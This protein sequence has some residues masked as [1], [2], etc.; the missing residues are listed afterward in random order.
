MKTLPVKTS[1]YLI[2]L[3]L[4]LVLSACGGDND[5]DVRDL[6]KNLNEAQDEITDLEKR[7]N[8]LQNPGAGVRAPLKMTILHMNDHHSHIAPETFSY[9]VAGL[10]LAARTGTNAELSSVSVTYGGFPM[11]VSLFDR[12]A[13]QSVN[14]VKIHA[15]DAVTGTLYY[16]LFNGA[17]DAAMMNQVCFDAFALGNHEFD[18]GD[19]GLANFLDDLKSG[20]CNTAVLAANVKPGANSAI[21]DGYIQP[22]MIRDVQGQKVGF[23]GI[24]IADK[25]KNSSKPDTDTQFLDEATTAQH[26][27]DELRGQGVNKIVLVTHY[28]YE[29]DKLLASQL[30]GVDVIVGGDSHTLLGGESFKTLGFNPA[31]EYPTITKNRDGDTVCIVQAWEYGHLLGKLEVS[32]DADG[33]VAAC[34]G[35]PYMPVADNFTYTHGAGDI[36]TLSASDAFKVRQQITKLP[37]V[38]AVVPDATTENLL[39][40]YNEEVSVLEQQVIGTTADNLCL[41]RFPG[42]SRS[43]ICNASETSEYG[44]DI[45]NIIA[46]AFMT[47]TPTADIAIQNGGG[48]RVDVAAGDIT[49][50]EAVN[51]L[52]FTNTL[53]TLELT[54]AQIKAV[55]EDAMSSALRVGGSSG[56]YPYAS[57]L[58]YHVNAS[59]ADGSRISN[60]EVNPRVN[61]D[62]AAINTT[63]TYTVVTNDFIAAGQDGYATFG[64]LY[65]AGL[66]VNT[67]TLYTQAFISYITRLTANGDVLTKLPAS[68]YSTQQY[69]GRDG[70]NHSLENCSGY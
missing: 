38:V 39:S 12:L 54:G 21:S 64:G 44:S 59:A 40:V 11:L 13:A 25:T 58:R 36:R 56:S 50:A 3:S 34:N 42:E 70:C 2:P 22:Y 18:N 65:D 23:I 62:W 63:A 49:F 16:S 35:M 14:P 4:A 43:T 24:D 51:V 28:Q 20:A 19:V 29:N 52:P 9:S 57:G 66:Y 5:R 30:S 48:V 67:F 32:F 33:K 47:V 17:A 61:G 26:Y 69:I 55:L 7:L 15:G 37:E 45:S 46:K 31:G 41:V 68:E 8:E 1:K 10:G 27:I 6:R 60:I 53:V